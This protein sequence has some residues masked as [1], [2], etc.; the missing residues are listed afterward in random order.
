MSSTASPPSL[1][2]RFAEHLRRLYPEETARLRA[3][4]PVP[5]FAA[6]LPL[7]SPAPWRWDWPHLQLI[8]ERL[9]AVTR[10]DVDRLILT[11]PPQHGKSEQATVRYPAWRL[12]RDRTLRVVVAA[13]NQEHANRFSRKA[14]RI[15]ERRFPLAGDRAAVQEWETA[16]GGSF[17]AVGV[18]AGITG[19]PA[20]LLIIDDPVKSREE[21]ESAAY[22]ERVW[23]WFTDDLYTRLQP[24]AA[25]VLIMT[26]W[27]EDDLAGR[28]LSGEEAG[29]WALLNLPAEAEGGD[30]LGRPPGAA[31]CPDRFD[32][33]ALAER[34][35][36]LGPSYYGLYQGRPR[37]RQGSL[38]QRQW[39]GVVD[40]A[41]A[42]GPAVRYWDKAATEGGGAYSAGCWCAA[43]PTGCTTSAT[44]SAASG[45]PTSASRPS[46]RRPAWTGSGSGTSRCGPS[47]SRGPAGK[48]SAQ[49]TVG[50]LAGFVAHA[51]PASG[52]KVVRAMPLA[53]QAEAGNVRLVRGDWNA[54]YLNELASFPS[55][56]Y[57]DQVDASSGAFNKLA[58]A[59]GPFEAGLPDPAKGQGSRAKRAP[60][61]VFGR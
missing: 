31:L 39:F 58:Q 41:P 14:R 27:H 52:D 18:G 47:R 26:R 51:E 11:V 60:G 7:V 23:G 13:Y 17:R 48:E 30:P 6:W 57:K 33:A 61:G 38:F 2:Q 45:P 49:A 19:Q 29:R 35:R 34:R 59:A 3:P 21:A 53:A 20:D 4:E 50:N 5:E 56:R 25:V 46:A 32:V 8:R 24:H 36:L 9:D 22:R 55:G 12:E 16:A 40:A 54:A 44:S 1:A 37:P 28:L 42:R 10:G 43:A 15:A